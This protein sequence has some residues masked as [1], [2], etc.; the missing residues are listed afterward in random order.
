MELISVVTILCM[1]LLAVMFAFRIP[2]FVPDPLTGSEYYY[3]RIIIILYGFVLT[4]AAA[5]RLG[6]VDTRVYRSIYQQ[7]GTEWA[8]AFDEA[9]PISDRG[10]NLF[11][12]LL[13]RIN[14]DPQFFIIVTSIIILGLYV[15]I[16]SKY[17]YNTIFS[18]YLLLLLNYLTSLNGIRQVMAAA[19]FGLS[20][21]WIVQRKM[22]PY[23][24][25]VLF[26]STLHASI[27]VMIPLYF[28]F[29]GKRLNLGILLFGLFIVTCFVF[30]NY[31]YSV[32]KI[33]LEDTVYSAYLDNETKMGIMRLFV[34]LVPLLITYFYCRL[35][36]ATGEDRLY[37]VLINMQ[38]VSVG[39]IA[40][41][42]RMV[43]FAR[44][45]MYCWFV[46]PLILPYTI[47]R[48]F[49]KESLAFVTMMAVI[50]YFV[51]YLYQIYVYH[52]MGYLSEFVLVF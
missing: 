7:I 4:F 37:D 33:L 30:P 40:L 19:I 1:F 27:L 9:A 49:N 50:L 13:N 28:I 45:S 44:I 11:M 22:L 51:Y 10:F 47:R 35:Y 15:Y 18:L 5:F 6:F 52:N 3:S 39:F 17:S 12:I 26:L 23:M 31:I 21:K 2:R 16:V 14:K 20:I 36:P 48:V 34:S 25:M 38:I 41:G 46:T 8:N 24:I 29:S 42:L 43:Y 32:M